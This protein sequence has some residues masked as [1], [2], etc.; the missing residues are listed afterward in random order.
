MNKLKNSVQLVGILLSY[1]WIVSLIVKSVDGGPHE[2]FYIIVSWI[3]VFQISTA[4]EFIKG[5]IEDEPKD[6]PDT[7]VITK[8]LRLALPDQPVT[9]NQVHA[10]NFWDYYPWADF[11]T[12][13]SDGDIYVW[14]KKPEEGNIFDCPQWL[15]SFDEF[16]AAYDCVK[17]G[18][19][20]YR[21]PNWQDH[22]AKRGEMPEW[23]K[24][25]L[26]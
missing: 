22:I 4:S 19:A 8:D 21:Q 5:L 26:P 6:K 23:L 18:P 14:E 10:G 1:Y 2:T 15:V 7:Q 3:A 12:E 16:D 9:I 17:R 25:S 11:V 13:D 24:K 20:K